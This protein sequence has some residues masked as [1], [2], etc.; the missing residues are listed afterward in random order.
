MTNNAS[1]SIS[2]SS[3]CDKP[4]CGARFRWFPGF[5]SLDLLSRLENN[6]MLMRF[7]FYLFVI[8]GSF[9]DNFLVVVCVV[10]WRF[11]AGIYFVVISFGGLGL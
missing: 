1:F 6:N 8:L 11:A 3:D 5:S 7:G 2:I 10:V 4:S 9:Y